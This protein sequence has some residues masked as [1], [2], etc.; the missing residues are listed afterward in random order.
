MHAPPCRQPSLLP[1]C[2]GRSPASIQ[3][4]RR[5]LSNRASLLGS[6]PRPFLDAAAW[7]FAT[8]PHGEFG[9][10][11]RGGHVSSPSARASHMPLLLVKANLKTQNVYKNKSWALNT[12][13][14]G[15]TMLAQVQL[16]ML[17]Q[18]LK[19]KVCLH[20][21]SCSSLLSRMQFYVY[22]LHPSTHD[23]RQCQNP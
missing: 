10:R 6:P 12:L 21:C 11:C 8:A 22:S 19:K 7:I 18:K 1:T 9:S 13:L 16:P 2:I 4:H 17:K 5:F 20:V 14:S 23:T 3:E 15:P